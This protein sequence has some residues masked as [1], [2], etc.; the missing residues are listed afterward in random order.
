MTVV[1]LDSMRPKTLK[2]RYKSHDYVLT[3]DPESREWYYEV[4]YVQTVKFKERKETM[5]KAQRAAE[6]HIDKTLD[7]RKRA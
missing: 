7:M 3:Y 6:S 4:T 5:N 2:K 1:A